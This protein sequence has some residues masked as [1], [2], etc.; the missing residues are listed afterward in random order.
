P[1]GNSGSHTA[2]VTVYLTP[3]TSR[4]RNVS[5]IVDDLR[6]R[7]KDIEGFEKIYFEKESAGPPVGKPIA[8]SVRGEDFK[9][10]EEIS[11][12]ISA[13]LN[14]IDGVSDITSDYELGR[15]EIRVRIDEKAA[16]RVYL[17]A[18]D[19]ASSIR[20]AFRGGVATAIKPTKAEEEIDVLVRFPVKW[21]DQKETF[22]KIL[23]PNRLG[24]LISL[25]KVAR[26]EETDSPARVR[27][28][29]G[30]RVVSVRAEVDNKKVTSLKANQILEEKLKNI[31]REYP[32]YTVKYGGEQE[33]NVRS[34]ESFL[35]A[36]GLAFFLIFMIL[37]ASF[38]SLI[39]PVIVMMAIPFGLIGVIWAFVFHGQVLSFF[40]MMG[41]VGLTGIVVND[42][43][44]LVEFINNLRR[45]GANRRD[46]ILEA[47][48]LRLRPVLLTTITTALGLT[49][50]AYGIGG[51]DPFLKPMAL[52]IV[53]GIVC[54]TAL[55]LIL[56]PC[57]Y[58]IIDDITL[59]ISGHATVQKNN[60]KDN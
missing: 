41:V 4:E 5:E 34:T 21:R 60:N 19:I 43:I 48:N 22:N 12:K 13:L 28:L 29:D 35:K 37:A 33:E 30:K 6:V 15:R 52:T 45:R 39:Q 25:N 47:A 58:A 46:S 16:S 14:K 32:G 44:V 1:Y 24:N 42:S 18:Q 8:V 53:W 56:I 10:L 2:Q 9:V 55:T 50:T 38:N 31:S 36:F 26:L 57:L 59:V 11:V 3:F 49:P 17:S 20:Y 23:I 51:G 7:V 54:A 40:M 27:H